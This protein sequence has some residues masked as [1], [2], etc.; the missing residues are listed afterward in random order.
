[1]WR[2]ETHFTLSFRVS[3]ARWEN[4]GIGLPGAVGGA[5]SQCS[6]RPAA[7]SNR[8]SKSASAETGA[9]SDWPT[10]GWRPA[11]DSWA[12]R[13][14]N[15]VGVER[16]GCATGPKRITVGVRHHNLVS[17]DLCRILLN[18]SFDVPRPDDTG[19]LERIKTQTDDEAGQPVQR[20]EPVDVTQESHFAATELH[21]LSDRTVCGYH[22]Q[23]MQLGARGVNHPTRS[24][25]CND[26]RRAEVDG[27]KDFAGHAI[28]KATRMPGQVL[29]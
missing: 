22:I 13:T 1:M 18:G 16:F 4:S 3:Q 7:R 2:S 25:Y 28:P 19:C 23:Q 29:C 21:R 8:L 11:S 24:R 17:A 26:R 6:S 5:R 20:H 9:D 15:Y 27:H 12:R 10:D 14:A